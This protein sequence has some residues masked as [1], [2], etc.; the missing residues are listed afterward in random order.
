MND[1]YHLMNKDKELLL[2][3][4]VPAPFTGGQRAVT[5]EKLVPAGEFPPGF[6]EIEQFIESRNY[7]KHK[8]HLKKWLAEW[9]MDTMQGFL[10]VTHGLSLNDTLWFRKKRSG[11]SWNDVS[12]YRN[13][14]SD[15]AAHTAFETGLH[16]L[17]LSSTSPEFTSEGSFAKCWIREDDIYLYKKNGSGMEADYEAYS[18]YYAGQ[19]AG[20]LCKDSVSYD[21]TEFKGSVTSRC[22][23]FTSESVGF[24]P[25]YKY[26]DGN[27][28]Y[29][30]Q[31]ILELM[32]GYGLEEDYRR[33]I[34]L[35]G[36]IFNPDRHFGNLG[37]LVDNETFDILG[38]APAFDHNMALFSQ[39][40]DLFMTDEFIR[41]YGHKMGGRFEQVSA[42][43]LT[44]PILR[45]LE[46]LHD[47]ALS[48]HGKYDVPEERFQMLNRMVRRQI[49]A[50]RK[51]G[52]GY[53]SEKD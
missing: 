44:R 7:A 12:L 33:L 40:A 48:P 31:E 10:D 34:V 2:F 53:S 24:M 52:I 30:Y 51:S 49:S 1:F 22:R 5:D 36:I 13:E 43:M 11:L 15:V 27:R 23:M 25:L 14:F 46:D 16:G 26:L 18:E 28:H 17:R 4:L 39:T 9:G 6:D 35:D 32:R 29:S 45:D 3:H 8:N 20:I 19:L 42:A 21:L 38:L 37:F 50:L 47:F 41:Q